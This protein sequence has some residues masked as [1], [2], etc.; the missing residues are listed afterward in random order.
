MIPT[1]TVF[2]L[3]LGGLLVAIGLVATLR[4]GRPLWW[5]TIATGILMIAAG[6]LTAAVSVM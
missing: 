4:G 1:G 2:L 5:V 3:I 6:G